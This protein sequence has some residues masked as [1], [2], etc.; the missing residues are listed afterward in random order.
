[1][2]V[3]GW[4]TST[5]STAVG[6]LLAD[7][8][9]LEAHDHPGARQRPGHQARLLPLTAELLDRA[10]LDWPQ[11]DRVAVGLGPGTFTGLRVGVASARALAQSLEIEIVGVSSAMALAHAAFAE[12]AIGAVITVVDARRGEVFVGAHAAPSDH[13]MPAIL[14]PPRPVAADRLAA[15]LD[16][17][18]GEAP[19]PAGGA[20]LAVGDAAPS[21]RGLLE[22]AGVA[23]PADESSLHLPRGAAFCELGARL[24]ARGLDAVRPDYCRPA[25]A[26][27]ALARRDDEH[28][29]G[30]TQG[31]QHLAAAAQLSHAGRAR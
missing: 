5:P 3:I 1:V 10:G 17:V 24:H 19:P 23:V 12:L 27:L 15:A 31:P 16:Q 13:R 2:N 8:T 26:E 6:L 30:R 22:D 18:I 20:W 4:D 29:N 11:L 28:G 25:D 7:S 14:S 9:V 21:A